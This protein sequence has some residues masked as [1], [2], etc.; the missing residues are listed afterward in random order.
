MKKHETRYFHCR[1]CTNAMFAVEWTPPDV[2]RIICPWCNALVATIARYTPGDSDLPQWK[3][4]LSHA[5][6]RRKSASD[7]PKAD[8]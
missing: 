3:P 8:E 7:P 2:L 4:R 1:W 6:S 5:P